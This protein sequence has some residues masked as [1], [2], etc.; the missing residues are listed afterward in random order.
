MGL[1]MDRET[2]LVRSGGR[3]EA[4]PGAVETTGDAILAGRIIDSMG[5]TP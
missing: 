5:V 2:F 3:R 1:A 4:A